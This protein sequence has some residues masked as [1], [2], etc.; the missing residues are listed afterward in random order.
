MSWTGPSQN[1][2]ALHKAAGDFMAE[3]NKEIETDERVTNAP[4]KKGVKRDQPQIEEA[5]ITQVVDLWRDGKLDKMKV[6]DLKSYAKFH[7]KCQIWFLFTLKEIS[8]QGKAKKMDILSVLSEHLEQNATGK[9][10][11]KSKRK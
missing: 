2:M 1:G 7:G 5:D 11:K 3:F 8:L 9:G 10:G 4:L 6:A